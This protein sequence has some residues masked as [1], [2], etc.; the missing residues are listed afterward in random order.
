MKDG[1]SSEIKYGIIILAA[2]DSSR[3]GAPKQLL[4]LRN[5]TFI[6]HVVTEAVKIP[7]AATIVV[8]GSSNE[9]VEQELAADSVLV[10]FNPAWEQGMSSSIRVGILALKE[11]FSEISCCIIAV[12]DQP[13]IST[14][15]FLNLIKEH[16]HTGF[17]IVAS[18]YAGTAGTPVLLSKSYFDELLLLE[19]QDGAKKILKD[20]EANVAF[21]PFSSG[22]VDVDT[23]EDYDRLKA[24]IA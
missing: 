2:G 14:A 20:H 22:E 15:V 17:G 7:N 24:S 23:V 8:T 3:L 9:T 5:G 16:E 21:I 6:S 18:T 13:F 1:M 12:C 4:K 11:R 19:G 10:C